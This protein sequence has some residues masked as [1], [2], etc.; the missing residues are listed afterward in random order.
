[1]KHLDLFSGIG[2]MSLALKGVS[3]AVLYCD[4]CETARKVLKKNCAQGKLDDVPILNDID[5]VIPYGQA[6]PDLQVTCVAAGFPCIGFSCAGSRAGFLNTESA[7]FFKLVDVC[8]YFK[9][10][11]IFMEN[12]PAIFKPDNY[13]I[14]QKSMASIGYHNIHSILLPAYA[15]GLPQ[16]RWRWFCIACRTDAGDVMSDM[17]QKLQDATLKPITEPPPR[18]M[19]SQAHAPNATVRWRLLK[20][21][22]V[23]AC[24]AL[25]LTSLLEKALHPSTPKKKYIKPNLYLRIQQG[26][27]VFER[28]LWPTLFGHYRYGSKVLTRRTS[29]DLL[30]ALK[31]EA[32]TVIG[33]VNFDFLEWLMGYERGWTAFSEEL[34]NEVQKPFGNCDS[35]GG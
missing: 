25:A 14:L 29:G 3:E 8:S 34:V 6:H 21:S 28:R 19:Q 10:K 16:N 7:L 15:T 2:G 12:T 20:N 32:D 5:E 13:N 24:A 30:T 18:T 22:L 33:I 1:M 35:S 27:K 4:K 17:H 31:F 9:P 23:P 26:P 11:V